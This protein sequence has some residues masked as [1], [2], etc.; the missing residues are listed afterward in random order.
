MDLTFTEQELAFQQEVR[1]FLVE[2]LPAH[3]IEA[4]ANNG[5]VFVEKDIALQ[6]QAILVEKGWAVPQWPTEHGGTDW[7]PA[8]K[9]LFSKECYLAGAPMLIPLG[10]LMLAPVIMAFG[11]EQ[12]KS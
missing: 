11:S 7:S 3:I 12:Q 8:Q 4:T 6:W 5:S 1:Q 10:L 9:Y 2:S